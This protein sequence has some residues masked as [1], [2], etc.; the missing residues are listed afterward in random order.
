[1]DE[2]PYMPDPHAL[3]LAALWYGA[4]LVAAGLA[5]PWPPDLDELAE[6]YFAAFRPA[7][8]A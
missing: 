6:R 1:M 7:A 8:R 5:Q 3:V 4:L 2:R